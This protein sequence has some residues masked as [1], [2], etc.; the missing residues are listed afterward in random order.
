MKN[1]FKIFAFLFFIPF[2]AQSKILDD[3]NYSGTNSPEHWGEINKNYK[4]CKIGLNQSPIDIKK[5]SFAKHDLSFDYRN[6]AI[7]KISEKFNLRI[8]FFE[9]NFLFRGKKKYLLRYF[10]FHHP[11]EHLIDG[12]PHSL[13]MQISHKSEDEQW[14]ILSVFLELGNHNQNFENLIEFLHKAPDQ[15][16]SKEARIAKIN[17]MMFGSK[18][19]PDYQANNEDKLL[20]Q[21]SLEHF[22][23]D[24]V[25]MINL[26]DL[27][28][29][30]EGSATTPPCFEGVKWYVMKNP[31]QISKEQMEQIIKLT[32]F[33]KTNARPAQEF[34]PK[35]F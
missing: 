15:T 18:L 14:L 22:E 8:N 6:K 9:S 11:S 29:F 27:A 30:Y 12:R 35:N 21:G 17:S 1:F 24:L 3:W 28:F 4:F 32:I 33:V 19:S 25:K 16:N 20:N 7:E 26:N 31:I 34:H 10:D 2:L 13:E 23:I 5:N